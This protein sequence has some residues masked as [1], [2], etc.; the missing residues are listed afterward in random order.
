MEPIIIVGIVIAVI[1]VL[2]TLIIVGWYFFKKTKSSGVEWD[3]RPNHN[4]VYGLAGK[5]DVTYYGMFNS[6]NDCRLNC[7][8]DQSCNSYAW[9][10]FKGFGDYNKKC[11]GVPSNYSTMKFQSG[12]MSGVKRK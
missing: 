1:L 5:P 4:A 8:N 3:L 10:P 9:H 2:L 12:M 6:E 11:Y 7:E